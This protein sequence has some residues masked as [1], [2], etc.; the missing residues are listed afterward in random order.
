M[1]DGFR[2]H[3]PLEIRYGDMDTLGH[4]NNAKYLTYIEH[5]RVHYFHELALW[6]GRLS[7]LGLI[8]ARIEID[9]KRPLTMFDKTA[10]VWARCSRLGN[11]SFD[12]ETVITSERDGAEQLASVSRAVMVVYDY[13]RDA[14][15]P[16]PDDWRQRITAYEPALS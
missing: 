7:A 8:V 10:H 1:P 3:I 13:Q 12:I 15:I 6:D 16:M 9:Y 2:F 5:A 4:V 14:T 11:K